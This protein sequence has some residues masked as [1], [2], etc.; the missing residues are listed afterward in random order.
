MKTWRQLLC[1]VTAAALFCMAMPVSATVLRPEDVTPDAVAPSGD[2]S[3]DG[4]VDTTDARLVLQHAVGKMQ[5]DEV[6]QEMTDVNGDGW[7]NTADARLILQ[8][9]VK[10]ITEF[11]EPETAFEIVLMHDERPAKEWDYLIDGH[12]FYGVYQDTR[13]YLFENGQPTERAVTWSSNNAAGVSVDPAG[14]ILIFDD[15]KKALITATLED[16]RCFRRYILSFPLGLLVPEPTVQ[17][18]TIRYNGARLDAFCDNFDII[19]EENLQLQF[20]AY[21]T[22]GCGDYPGT[23]QWTSSD[24]SIASVDDTG[25]VTLHRPGRILLQA[26]ADD[27]YGYLYLV[28][29]K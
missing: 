22:Y 28:I 18:V 3:G 21:V 25:L 29:H 13:L 15:D 8:Y 23:V 9:A 20:T 6:E 7:V 26:T 2:V 16:G 11:P 27:H 14:C 17:G 24:P 1:A 19:Y 5:L 12:F 4:K 10:K